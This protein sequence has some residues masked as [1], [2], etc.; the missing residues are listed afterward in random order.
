MTAGR[1][2]FAV[3]GGPARHVPVLVRPVLD[4]LNVR[5]G[6]VTIDGTFGAGGYSRA[7]L[8]TPGA[9]VIGIDRD[10]TAVANGADLVQAAAG[11]LTLVEARFSQ[12]DGVAR[13]FGHAAVDGVV[14]DLG[15]SSMQID[16]AERGFS[17]RL[18]GPLDMRMGGEGPSAADVVARALER[19]LANIIFLLGE[20]RHSRA[21]A[22][23]IVQARAAAP[24]RST[25]ALAEIVARVVRGKPGA[26]HPAT[27]TFQALR[28]F[29]NEELA[30]LAVALSAA[31]RVL[32]PGGRLAVVAFHSLEDRIVKTFFA[33][34]GPTRAGSRHRP[35]AAGAAPTFRVLTKRPIV[36]DEAEVAANPRARSARLRA[37]ERTEAAAREAGTSALLPRLPS[38]ADVL[39]G[40]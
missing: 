2:G 36:P 9:A 18:D 17:F 19:D 31:E 39:R 14:L 27:R 32:K 7:I 25:A 10:R 37:A 1:D 16:Q 26:I 12:L 20:E 6:G 29:V 22:R 4:Q 24:I 28:L 30:E 8:A 5:A 23:A 34:R 33:D 3:A 35:D 21:V 40:R 38:L 15:V 13:K 11:R